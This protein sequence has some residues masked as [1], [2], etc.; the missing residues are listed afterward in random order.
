MDG[1]WNFSWYHF[2]N[3]HS[4]NNFVNYVLTLYLVNKTDFIYFI[5]TFVTKYIDIVL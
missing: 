1:N 2:N 3:H 4:F 5:F